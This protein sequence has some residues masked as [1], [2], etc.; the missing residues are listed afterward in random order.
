MIAL[1]MS[2]M[3]A[4]VAAT[5][6]AATLLGINQMVGTIEPGK[7]ADLLII[8]GN[9]LKRIEL[10]RDRRRIIGVMQGG[11]FVAG[12]LTEG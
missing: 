1:G 12:P 6:S 11:K 8:D 10:L 7:Q 2:P 9:P 4:L 5:S 3:D